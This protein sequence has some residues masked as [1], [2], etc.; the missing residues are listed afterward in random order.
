MVARCKEERTKVMA[1]SADQNRTDSAAVGL[2]VDDL[3]G[4]QK[5]EPRAAMNS[6]SDNREKPNLSHAAQV[7]RRRA[8]VYKWGR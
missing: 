2:S 7:R 5:E 1:R 3:T 8:K 4:E 6:T